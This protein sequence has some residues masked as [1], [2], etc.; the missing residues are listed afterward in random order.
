MRENN[1]AALTIIV[2]DDCDDIRELLRVTL[3]MRGYLVLEAENGQVA[4]ELAKQKCPDLILMDLNMPVLDGLAATRHLRELEEMCRVPIIAVSA[5][6]KDSHKA[7]AFAAGCNEYLS[8]PVN[9]QELDHLL[10]NLLAA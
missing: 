7:D 4:V 1:G 9:F 6:S 3:E 8:K 5:N 2:V 10:D